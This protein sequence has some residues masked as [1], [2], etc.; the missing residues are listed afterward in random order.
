MGGVLEFFPN[1]KIP[2]SEMVR[3]LKPGGILAVNIVPNKFSIQRIADVQRT[4]AH[5]LFNLINGNLINAF[6]LKKHIPSEY[7]IS[8]RSLNDYIVSFKYAGLT[9]V[10]GLYCTPYPAIAL[11]KSLSMAYTNYLIKNIPKWKAFNKT[12]K[13]WHAW[14]AITFAIYGTKTKNW[15]LSR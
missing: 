12:S 15:N 1:I 9:N 10:N 8:S 13:K 7:P 4:I 5:G 11:P 2:L 6:T 14:W 3:V